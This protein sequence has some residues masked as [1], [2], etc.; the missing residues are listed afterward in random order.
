MSID[1]MTEAQQLEQRLTKALTAIRAH[2][3]A[4]IPSRP[5]SGQPGGGDRTALITADDHRKDGRWHVL[6]DGHNDVDPTTRLATIKRTT[7][8]VLNGWCRVIMEDRPVEEALP[9]GRSVDSMS[10]FLA[11]HA[12]WMSGHEAAHDMADEVVE[13]AQAIKRHV[14]PEPPSSWKI[15]DCPLEVEQDGVMVV[16]GGAVRYREDYRD[17]DGEAMP[18]CGRCGQEAVVSWWEDRMF[19]DPELRKMLTY[20]DVATLAHRILGRPVHRHTVKMWA[21]RE[22]IK[23]SGERDDKGRVLFAREATVYALDLWKR[24]SA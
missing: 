21:N 12:Q 18:K 11:T 6:G 16:C 8:D 4:L 15:G 14:S 2:W 23:P 9:D 20:D 17:K 7:I 5:S 1:Y 19:D 22:I 24:Q 10:R 3:P 13:I